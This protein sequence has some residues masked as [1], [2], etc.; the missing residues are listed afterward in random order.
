VRGRDRLVAEQ[1]DAG[2]AQALA[3]T[4]EVDGD[5]HR[6]RVTA[7]QRQP[8]RVHGLEGRAERLAHALVV[9]SAVIRTGLARSGEASR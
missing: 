5:D 2:G 3:Q 8:V 4:L 9:G 6:G 1:R 7:V